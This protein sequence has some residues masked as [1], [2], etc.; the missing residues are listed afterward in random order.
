M[1]QDELVGLVGYAI[2]ET[3]S[4]EQRVGG[5]IKVMV[6]TKDGV[7]DLSDQEVEIAIKRLKGGL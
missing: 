6:I 5:P 4:Q 2:T 3:E 1:S 7:K